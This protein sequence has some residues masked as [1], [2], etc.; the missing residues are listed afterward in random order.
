M[1]RVRRA[2]RGT[3]VAV[4]LSVAL[5]AAVIAASALAAVGD[6][7]QGACYSQSD[8]PC[9]APATVASALTN[10]RSLAV[11]PDGNNVYAGS[12]NNGSVDVFTRSA[13]G[14]LAFA[15]CVGIASGCTSS[16]LISSPA[17]I[18]ISPD[19]TSVYVAAE[20]SGVIDELAR[21]TSSG[22]LTYQSCIGDNGSCT[23]T[24]GHVTAL[25]GVT[26]VT[27]SPDG[28]NVY[29][30]SST[31]DTLSTFTRSSSTGALSG[32][33][34][35]G[36]ATGCTATSPVTLI[37]QP[38][39]VAVSP[40]G[41]NVYVGSYGSDD[42]SELTRTP[43]S[44]ALTFVSCIGSL[45][46]C[47]ATTAAPGALAGVEALA[48]SP[49]GLD[50]YA[51]SINNDVATLSRASNG[52]LTYQGCLGNTQT[53]GCTAT[54]PA[55]A[56]DGVVSLAISGDG[57]SLYAGSQ[58]AAVMA[59]FGR[60]SSG[61]L[62][63]NNCLG[64]VSGCTAT[65]PT[66][67]LN[68]VAA[69]ALSPDGSSVYT[70]AENTS[71]LALF[72]RTEPPPSCQSVTETIPYN[73][74]TATF[75]IPCSDPGGQP[76]HFALSEVTPHGVVHSISS[77]GVVS[78]SAN[79][80]Y[81]GSDS[82]TFTASNG[83]GSSTA[84]VNLTI[85]APPAPI[86]TSASFD[87]QSLAL[88]TPSPGGCNVASQGLAFTISSTKAASG[89]KKKGSHASAK[90]KFVE[91]KLFVD[92]GKKE[93]GT[94]RRHHKKVHYTYLAPNQTVHQNPRTDRLAI[95]G[96]PSGTHTLKVVFIY[97]RAGKTVTKTLSTTFTVC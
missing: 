73:T 10:V 19:G 22:A 82:F 67:E 27:V 11:S 5:G 53:L 9:T 26:G 12:N 41:N 69:I 37:E 62:T 94:R 16:S 84:T 28:K 23:A 1:R 34:C 66:N 45:P 25:V 39:S 51:G 30:V 52:A 8:S 85:T 46:G 74:A 47:T 80:D 13:T 7:A 70:A 83:Y 31:E 68:D 50:V 90:L 35:I 58:N 6:L 21:N 2:F 65:S 95:T 56:L 64:T 14:A 43:S 87:G 33:S 40:D 78:Y 29:A 77:A 76:L 17:S 55:G 57:E 93:T 20:G 72:G 92:G 63:L 88:T 54:S 71:V 89:K 32:F 38:Y 91:A 96:L 60:A 81:S 48:I 75:T 42:V 49:D 18:A 36:N 44:G 79:A 86:R 3:R 59:V 24:T 15:S 4:A 61:A 97:K